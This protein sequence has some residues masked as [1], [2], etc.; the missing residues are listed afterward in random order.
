[1]SFAERLSRG[2]T[3]VHKLHTAIT[4]GGKRCAGDATTTESCQ[5]R[6]LLCIGQVV[7]DGVYLKEEEV[8]L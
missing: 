8:A 2:E 3:G 4:D 6:D 1:M 7:S 5:D